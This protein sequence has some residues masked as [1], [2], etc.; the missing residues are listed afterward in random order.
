MAFSLSSGSGVTGGNV[1]FDAV[2]TRGF[3]PGQGYIQLISQTQEPTIQEQ[4][5][6]YMR[7][8][9]QNKVSIPVIWV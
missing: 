9:Y 6:D 3:V 1:H 5:W 4:G 2:K 7:I 8:I